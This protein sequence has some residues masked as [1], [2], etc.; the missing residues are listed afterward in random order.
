MKRNRFRKHPTEE[1]FWCPNCMDY[2][3]KEAFYPNV[4]RKYEIEFQC[5]KCV[6]HRR[7][8]PMKKEKERQ[9]SNKRKKKDRLI[10]RD[11]YIKSCLRRHGKART[12]ETINLKRQSIIMQQTLTDFKQWRKENESDHEYVHGKQQQ[13]EADHERGIQIGTGVNSSERV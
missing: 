9:N 13:N 8:L 1:L 4:K 6:K 2:L 5:K 3:D 7:N 12:P 11:S 10:L